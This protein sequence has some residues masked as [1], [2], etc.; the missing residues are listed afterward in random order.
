MHLYL[1]TGFA[2]QVMELS[3][4]LT[5]ILRD[6]LEV[7]ELKQKADP[8][9]IAELYHRIAQ[10]LKDRKKILKLMLVYFSI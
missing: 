4:T 1:K 2:R 5:K 9:M 8:E 3:S 6:T 7:N 10:V